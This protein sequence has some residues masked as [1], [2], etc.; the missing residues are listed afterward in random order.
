M[1]FCQ[2]TY[3]F[4]YFVGNVVQ[5]M[6]EHDSQF[7]QPLAV[8]PSVNGSDGGACSL[9]EFAAKSNLDI[10]YARDEFGNNIALVLVLNEDFSAG[11][12]V[13]VENSIQAVD[14]DVENDNWV[15]AVEECTTN[16]T[17]EESVVSVDTNFKANPIRKYK[18]N[19][20]TNMKK[21]NKSVG[22]DN[23]KT[24]KGIK[25]KI[26][27]HKKNAFRCSIKHAKGTIQKSKVDANFKLK[28]KRKRK[29]KTDKAYRF[30]GS[31]RNLTLESNGIVNTLKY[32]YYD[33]FFLNILINEY[34]SFSRKNHATPHI[35]TSQTQYLLGCFHP[36]G[37]LR[38][39]IPRF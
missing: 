5:V 18:S 31:L 26:T 29:S 34:T 10:I 16:S 20:K 17:L 35:S 21:I 12:D 15:A 19:K 38:A 6:T 4:I 13:K 33:T 32:T 37:I 23:P 8:I 25:N 24:L 30:S 14:M 36:N 39:G 3:I 27:A 28:W 11:H 7:L 22:K 9:E 2:S 1:I